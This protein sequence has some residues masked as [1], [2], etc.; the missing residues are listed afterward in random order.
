MILQ[1]RDLVKS[2]GVQD[3]LK[4]VSFEIKEN[5]RVAV[6][7]VN[8]AGK[9]T[10][11]RLLTGELLPDGGEI[12]F[13]KE[14][15]VGFLAQQQDVNPLNNAFDELMGVF[16][17]VIALENAL[18]RIETEMTNAKDDKLPGL[19][20]KYEKMTAEFER[21][22][23]YTYK[24]LVKGV[25]KGLGFS[26]EEVK[27][28][29]ANLSGGQKTRVSLGK[30][31][32]QEPDLLLLDEPT[33]H[34]DMQAVAWLEDYLQ[35]TYKGAVLLISHD[36][37]FLDRLATKIVEIEYGVSKVYY[38]NYSGYAHQK[39]IDRSL[40]IKRVI[41]QQR[42]IKR[43]EEIIRRFRSYSQEWS[44]RRA[45]TREKMLAKVVRLEMP[46]E[47]HTIRIMLEPRKH[48]GHDVLHIENLSM[49]F[50]EP[51]FSGVKFD[52]YR[53]DVVALI[54]PNGVGKTTLLNM[55]LGH[56][57]GSGLIR[58]GAGVRIGYYDQEQ[59]FDEPEKTLFDEVYDAYPG[60]THTEVRTSLA[61]FMFCGDDVFKAVGTLSGGEKGR[62]SLCKLML[63]HSNFLL[64]D[65]PTNHLDIFSREILEE[66][67]RGYTGTIL[68]V[69]HDRY[70]INSTADKI[71][72]LNANGAVLYD[73]GYDYYLEKRQDMEAYEA[74]ALKASKTDYLIRK[75]TE[76][77]ERKKA[78]RITR[79]EKEIA[80]AEAEI[81]KLD[82]KL[83]SDEIATD[84]GAAQAVY[85]E[86][87]ALDKKV[88]ILFDEWESLH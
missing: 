44:V 43:Q 12:A 10:V 32:L 17:N 25:V 7:G 63:G 82:E 41:N 77:G 75:E 38:G 70:F 80:E 4:Q 67:V 40:Q 60:L 6:V 57:K 55:L 2:F 13:R 62:L 85:A 51:L 45:K 78:A 30:L 84:A 3:V 19:L 36:R 22:R 79:L 74:L 88:Q 81:T 31:L 18:R 87:V 73:G 24:S 86:K 66:A 53:G 9:T 52:I 71:I 61:A 33:N 35:K 8:G 58:F 72:E 76:S 48:S 37:Y 39:D 23:G 15:S 27:L 68:Y 49:A 29:L 16:A 14:T 28:P 34:L 50:N 11:F 59:A 83:M 5:E 42:E 26:D 69:S 56:V 54:G 46:K 21:K 65:E 64:M 20:Q 1:C 47:Q